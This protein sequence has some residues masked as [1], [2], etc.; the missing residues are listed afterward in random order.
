MTSKL[1]GKCW[2]AAYS[3]II[4]GGCH[5]FF[6]FFSKKGRLSLLKQW[7]TEFILQVPRN[8]G[9]CYRNTFCDTIMFDFI[10]WKILE[11]FRG[12]IEGAR[13]GRNR[14]FKVQAPYHT[15]RIVIHLPKKSSSADD[16][17]WNHLH[18][19]TYILPKWNAI[20]CV[21]GQ[22]F[23]TCLRT[24]VHPWRVRGSYQQ[25]MGLPG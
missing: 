8:Q 6:F 24:R 7:R 25:F 22:L 12:K 5:S 21:A 16:Q 15:Q 19:C 1:A 23:W 2:S 20:R 17:R 4:L 18:L 14:S 3:L 10:L 9:A 13:F 11:V